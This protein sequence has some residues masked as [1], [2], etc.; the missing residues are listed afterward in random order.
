MERLK[1]AFEDQLKAALLADGKVRVS[2]PTAR[3]RLAPGE[4]FSPVD[5]LRA[6]KVVYE[7]EAER[8]LLQ[9]WLPPRQQLLASQLALPDN[10]NRFDDLCGRLTAEAVIPFV[11][12]GMSRASGL[13]DW[14]GLLESLLERSTCRRAALKALL[15][16]AQYEAAADLLHHH[17]VP[18]AF[19]EKLNHVCRVAREKL[20]GPILLLPDLFQKLLITTNFDRVLEDV[21]A[22]EGA[23]IGQ[24]F[25]GAD[26]RSFQVK[27]D[28]T[29]PQLLKLH[30][31]YDDMASR[32]FTSKEYEETY[33]AGGPL[34]RPAIN[35]FS[36]TYF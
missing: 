19:D 7:N 34:I 15:R 9:Q 28:N 8:W 12:A 31:S 5:I 20:A 10:Q 21:Y 23:D 1:R 3:G 13:P 33:K 36:T 24:I 6:D 29:R 2:T 27:R 32:V 26:M 16:K 14:G 18:V 4:A 22:E 35:Y 25:A 11:G 30:G 17:A